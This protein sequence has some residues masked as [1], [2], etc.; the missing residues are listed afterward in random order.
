MIAKFILETDGY[1]AMFQLQPHEAGQSNVVMT[2][3]FS[4]HRSVEKFAVNSIS[5]VIDLNDLERLVV[6]LD[7]HI[8]NLLGNAQWVSDYFVPQE[9]GFEIRAQEGIIRKDG[10]GTFSLLLMVNV[11]RNDQVFVGG[12]CEVSV[13][14]IRQF[15]SSVRQILSNFIIDDWHDS[16]ISQPL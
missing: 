10:Q 4:L 1:Q 13:E 16:N 15:Q 3:E 12:E 6:Y 11:N 8:M 7:Q 14:S 2:V 5:T 9:L